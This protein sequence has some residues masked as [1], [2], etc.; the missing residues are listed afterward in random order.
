L[1]WDDR[2]ELLI[3]SLTA[4]GTVCTGGG[5]FFDVRPVGG[6][7]QIGPWAGVSA[8]ALV[9]FF[10]QAV[11]PSQGR[12]NLCLDSPAGN[13]AVG[14]YLERRGFKAIG[15]TVLMYRG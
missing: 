10:D 9:D 6:I 1:G 3:T 11:A 14:R 4:E 8:A 15:S 12:V 5:A 2:R 13:G 7:S